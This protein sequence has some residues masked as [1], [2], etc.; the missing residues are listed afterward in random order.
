MKL[1]FLIRSLKPKREKSG[2]QSLTSMTLHEN[3]IMACTCI[4]H[5]MKA[6]KHGKANESVEEPSHFVTEH[7]HSP[8]FF[9]IVK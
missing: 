8:L 1:H 7:V 4:I 3:P 2:L 6:P 9:K 5:E